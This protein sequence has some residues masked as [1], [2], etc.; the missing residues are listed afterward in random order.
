MCS[1][2]LLRSMDLAVQKKE[3]RASRTPPDQLH[4]CLSSYKGEAAPRRLSSLFLLGLFPESGLQKP[5]FIP[6]HPR[7]KGALTKLGKG[8]LHHVERQPMQYP[9][10]LSFAKKHCVENDLGQLWELEAPSSFLGYSKFKTR[11]QGLKS[12]GRGNEEKATPHQSHPKWYAT[13]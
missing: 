7:L 4:S 12:F 9:Q 1:S 5:I 2:N 3:E 11:A 8:R 10:P 6:P 13:D